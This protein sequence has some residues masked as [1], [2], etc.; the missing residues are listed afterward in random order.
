MC[1]S[2][3]TFRYSTNLSLTGT[4]V[5]SYCYYKLTLFCCGCFTLRAF[6]SQ[7]IDLKTYFCMFWHFCNIET[8]NMCQIFIKMSQQWL[9]WFKFSF[10]Q[11]LSTA[12]GLYRGLNG[13]E[14]CYIVI[15]ILASE[16]NF[17]ITLWTSNLKHRWLTL[18]SMLCFCCTICTY[19]EKVEFGCHS[20]QCGYHLLYQNHYL[21]PHYR[22]FCR[23]VLLQ[24]V[25]IPH[26]P[27]PWLPSHSSSESS[28]Q[29]RVR[30]G[31]GKG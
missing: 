19:V 13:L 22:L 1:V 30:R 24:S 17:T 2:V 10:F 14:I 28:A 21:L 31:S 6:H 23:E 5:L 8:Y 26:N 27:S 9:I 20:N 7:L 18:W 3:C 15:D 4:D 29:Q 11:H 16:L 12:V 25:S